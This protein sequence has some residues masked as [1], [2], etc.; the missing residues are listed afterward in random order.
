MEDEMIDFMD[1]IKDAAKKYGFDLEYRTKKAFK[2]LNEN[3]IVETNVCFVTDNDTVEIDVIAKIPYQ[4]HFLVECKGTHSDSILLLVRDHNSRTFNQ[5]GSILSSSDRL[6]QFTPDK[7]QDFFTFTGD[8][9]NK[10]GGEL[11]PSSKNDN[12]NNL[13]KAQVQIIDA[14]QA[15]LHYKSDDAFIE[16]TSSSGQREI[17]PLIVTN[18]DI[19]VINYGEEPESVKQY[20]WVLHNVRVNSKL[21][22]DD[23]RENFLIL[24][25]SIKYLQ[26]LITNGLT[27]NSEHWSVYIKSG[28]F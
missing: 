23:S 16:D 10:R 7:D 11:K 27:K 8:F 6:L 28:M 17:I 15:Y 1:A 14:I 9:F 19:W 26:E 21:N 20:K 25:I 3:I 18:A 5:Q 24:I 22:L 12:D 13:Y 2:N 4:Y